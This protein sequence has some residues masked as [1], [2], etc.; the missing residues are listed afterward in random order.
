MSIF[1]RKT[2]LI[3][4]EFMEYLQDALKEDPEATT[5]EILT[6]A[7]DQT[8]RSK[9]D[10]EAI[11]IRLAEEKEKQ[12]VREPEAKS[13]EKG[14]GTSFLEWYTKLSP[15]IMCLMATGF[16]YQKAESLYKEVDKSVVEEILRAFSEHSWNEAY[17]RF[18][19]CLFGFGGGYGKK[20]SKPKGDENVI[21]TR[22]MDVNDLNSLLMGG[23]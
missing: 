12:E 8:G 18:E 13:S 17:L 14:F 22:D 1:T 9:K 3:T 19:A 11:A 5:L 21:D 20:G 10:M 4:F 7:C 6:Y 2:P 15:D 23:R 16:D